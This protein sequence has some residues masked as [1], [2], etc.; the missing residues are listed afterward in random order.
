[1]LNGII[2]F[3]GNSLLQF[4]RSGGNQETLSVVDIQRGGS[5][6]TGDVPSTNHGRDTTDVNI[7][8]RNYRLQVIVQ[9]N[10]I[11]DSLIYE[12]ILGIIIFHFE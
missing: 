9:E 10:S 5:M 1:M 6:A 2:Y 8:I 3:H 4:R 11:K 7:L 12:Y